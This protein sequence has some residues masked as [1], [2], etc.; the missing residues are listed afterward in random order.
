MLRIVIAVLVFLA[1]FSARAAPPPEINWEIT[2][3]FAPFELFADPEAMFATW[4]LHNAHE[5]WQGWHARRWVESDHRLASPY[6][7]ALRL[8]APTHWNRDTQAH[9]TDLL[10]FVKRE[11][12]PATTVRARLW[13]EDTQPCIWQLGGADLPALDCSVGVNVNLPLSGQIA[14]VTLANGTEFR[15]HIRP[16]HKVI[17]GLGDSYASGQG[18][19]DVPAQWQDSLTL[20]DG[21]VG[22]MT[23]RRNLARGGRARWLD[24]RCDRSFFSFQSL[25]ALGIAARD[26][27][28]FVSF[29]HHACTGAEIFDGVLTPQRTD[30]SVAPYNRRSQLNAVIGELCQSPVSDYAAISDDALAGID[31]FPLRRRNRSWLRPLDPVDR[32]DFRRQR[33]ETGLDE[34]RSGVLNCPAGQLR[35]PD[36]V[37]LSIGGNDVGFAQLVQYFIAP[38]IHTTYL[39]TDLVLPDLCP[40]PEF[41]VDPALAPHAAQYCATLDRKL[42]HDVGDLVGTQRSS[43]GIAVK[44]RLLF[45]SLQHYLRIPKSRIVMAQY[46]DPLRLTEAAPD[47]CAP[48]SQPA[49]VHGSPTGANPYGPWTGLKTVAPEETLRNWRFNLLKDESRLILL[50]FDKLREQLAI[51]ARS[52]NVTFACE[53]RDAYLGHGWWQGRQLT[54]PNSRTAPWAPSH[55]APYRYERHGRAVRTGNDCALTQANGKVAI[56]G[57]VH[58][59]LIGHTLIADALMRRLGYG[60]L[61][62]PPRNLPPMAPAEARYFHPRPLHRRAKSGTTTGLTK[63][64]GLPACLGGIETWRTAVWTRQ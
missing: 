61:P 29:L 34:P 36:L 41:R 10:R 9:A 13:L 15:Q 40:A 7:P 62:P 5:S 59:N 39:L 63:R 14:A 18:N 35:A 50:Q 56:S 24:E 51:T 16:D 21:N 43:T 22:W 32:G 57:A 23:T 3:R 44:Y 26:P 46:P 31:I 47:P 54:L 1:P 38:V 33:T 42:D 37:L 2:N 30:D 19:P 45:N 4:A 64:S 60:A 6:A 49:N 55:W 20:G 12:D 58:P 11:R 25:T 27:H 53:T 17:L 28:V 52:E 48:V 8:G